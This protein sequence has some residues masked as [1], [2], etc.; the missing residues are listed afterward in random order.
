MTSILLKTEN[1][2]LPIQMKLSEKRKKISGF[3]VPFIESI[4]IFNH[5]QTKDSR[6]S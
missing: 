6:Q 4:S 1:L 5:F 3:F 2:P